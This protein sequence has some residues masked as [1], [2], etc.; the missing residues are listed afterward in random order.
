MGSGRFVVLDWWRAWRKGSSIWLQNLKGLGPSGRTREAWAAAETVSPSSRTGSVW[1]AAALW[2]PSHVQ[3]FAA[4]WTVACQAP[5]HG[6]SPGKNTGVGCY[7][8]L[9]GN[10]PDLGI[11]PVSRVSCLASGFFT[12]EPPGK[13][14]SCCYLSLES[15]FLPF[16]LP[17]SGL[18]HPTE[19]SPGSSL[20]VQ[21]LRFHTPNAGGW[22]SILGQGTRSNMPQLRSCMLRLKIPH[23][24]TE[25]SHVPQLKILRASTKTQHSQIN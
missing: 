8:L 3:L 15:P 2:L 13:P 1:V 16:G 9:Q 11:K 14:L 25:R 24:S 23:A 4:L 21:W 18:S 17:G 5:V 12:S 7:A 22:G 19:G 20:V 10:L 6:D